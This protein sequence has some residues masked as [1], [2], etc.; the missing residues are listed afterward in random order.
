MEFLQSSLVVGIP[1]GVSIFVIAI[2]AL[3][4]FGPKKLPE[5]GRAA[6]Q[7]L[8]EFKNATNGMMK[9]HDETDKKEIEKKE[10]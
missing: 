6:G 5:F 2:I 1:G 10:Q 8:R 9:E 4:L 3:I 7:T